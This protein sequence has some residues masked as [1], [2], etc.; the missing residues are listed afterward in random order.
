MAHTLTKQP[1]EIFSF[2]MDF[3]KMLA[4]TETISTRTVTAVISGT[5]TDATSTVIDSSAISSSIIQVKVK[6]GA[7]GTSYKITIKITTSTGN[8]FEDEV[9]M[10]V[11][12]T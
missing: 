4:S 3:G 2:N 8:V 7:T 5:S 9:T 6:A 11:T 1:S 12:E 10:T